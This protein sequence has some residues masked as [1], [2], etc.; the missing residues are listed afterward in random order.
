MRNFCREVVIA[1]PGCLAQRQHPF[2]IRAVC[3]V[4]AQSRRGPCQQ[5]V[6]EAFEV[7]G[8]F[9]RRRGGA[10]LLTCRV[11]LPCPRQ[12]QPIAHLRGGVARIRNQR[13]AQRGE[14]FLPVA[15]LI[16]RLGRGRKREGLAGARGNFG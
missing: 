16:E 9:K 12:Q 10:K 7:A 6:C 15:R 1:V 2:E 11:T 5:Q 8:P 13:A 3:H 14:R 4:A